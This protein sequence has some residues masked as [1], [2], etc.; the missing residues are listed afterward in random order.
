[1]VVLILSA[2]G[3]FGGNGAISAPLDMILVVVASLVCYFWGV[4]ASLDVPDITEEEDEN[5]LA[6]GKVSG[7][8]V[9]E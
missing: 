4:K 5:A 6:E 8:Y 1:M 9:S 2:L 3:T 7:K